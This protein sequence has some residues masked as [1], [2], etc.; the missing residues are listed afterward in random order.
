LLSQKIWAILNRKT[1]KG[2]DY[3]DALFL[4]SI[5]RPDYSYLEMKAGIKDIHDLRAKLGIKTDSVNFRQLIKDVNPFLIYPD[6]NKGLNY[7]PNL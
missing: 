1:P 7:F 6:D 5:A 3:Y 4:F 2:R